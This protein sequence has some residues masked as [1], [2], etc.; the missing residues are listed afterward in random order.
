[1][2]RIPIARTGVG[3]PRTRPA[4]VIAGRAYS[5]RMIRGHLRGRQ[6]P[7]TIPER[8]DQAGHRLRPGSTGGRPPAFDRDHHKHR[9]KTACR[10]GLLKQARAMATR[11]DKL[12]IRYEAT[13]HLAVIRQSI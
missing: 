8:R 3:R 1:M 2:G 13:V 12:A 5:S 7:H 6:I 4:H 11:N 10:I 9:H